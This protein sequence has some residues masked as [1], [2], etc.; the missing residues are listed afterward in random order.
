M[1][2]EFDPKF[3][4]RTEVLELL[5]SRG[6][7]EEAALLRYFT[8]GVQHFSD[9][10]ALTGMREAVARIHRAIQSGESI[11]IYGDYDA[12]GICS[13]SILYLALLD[14]GARVNWYIPEREEGYGLHLEAIDYLIREHA[15]TLLITC[16]CGISAKDD[17]AVIMQK[18]IDVIVTDHHEL[19]EALPVCTVVNP[20]QDSNPSVTALCGA[21]VAYKVI[22]AL[23]GREYA[24]SYLDI[25]TIATVADSVDL[26]GENRDIV[27]EGLKMLNANPRPGIKKL[28]EK[29]GQKEVTAVQLAFTVVPRINAAGRVGEAKRA[30][31]L[32]FEE[33]ESRLSEVVEELDRANTERQQLCEQMLNELSSD[34]RFLS[35]LRGSVLVFYHPDWQ[36]GVIGIV[37]SK[38]T[39]RYKRPV[40]IFCDA[41]GAIKGSG[42]SVEGVN[43]FQLLSEMQDILLQFG[44]HS[45]AAGVSLK[46]E[47]LEEFRQRACAFAD[48]AVMPEQMQEYDAEIDE[49]DID[50]SLAESLARMEPFGVGN[51]RPLFLVQPKRVSVQPMKKHE[52]HLVVQTPAFE[53]IGFYRSDLSD[54]FLSSY[55]KKLIIDVGINE[56]KGRRYLK[57]LLRSLEMHYASEG[58][59]SEVLDERYM[60]QLAVKSDAVPRFTLYRSLNEVIAGERY[61]TLLLCNTVEAL[62]GFLQSEWADDFVLSVFAPQDGNNCNRLLF[63]PDPEQDLSCYEKIVFLDSPLYSGYV[64]KLSESGKAS[65]YLPNNTAAFCPSVMP[66]LSREALGGIWRTL[67]R[68][69]G[70]QHLRTADALYRQVCA[71]EGV[72]YLQFRIALGVFCELGLICKNEYYQTVEGVRCELSQSDFYA[73][74]LSWCVRK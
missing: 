67:R 4:I 8:A 71:I 36:A 68:V 26:L 69:L 58:N 57:C 7:A 1:S 72:G 6:I 56:Y 39:D 32:F 51:R 33:D 45:Q 2:H 41:D 19:P 25:A 52:E 14:K 10:F 31:S 37:A 49:N 35:I 42:R 48:R 53:A 21:G 60:R 13:V 12:D 40:F 70:S 43:L 50:L 64:A 44:G 55:P 22:E 29:S 11:V 5:S 66:D 47:H 74:C 46:A 18:G 62:H 28:L 17:I 27:T 20:K 30:L 73:R 15:P 65:I 38:L 3:H 61:G 59:E 54:S 9:P 16:D 23:F 24:L 63:S 34:S